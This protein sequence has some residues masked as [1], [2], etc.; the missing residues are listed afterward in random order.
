[1][2]ESK[3]DTFSDTYFKF[4]KHVLD[5]ATNCKSGESLGW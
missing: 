2:Y 4:K 1:M 5:G 3:I